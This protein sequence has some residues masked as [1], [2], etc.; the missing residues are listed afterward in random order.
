MA[1]L[2]SSKNINIY[3]TG[4]MGTGKSSVASCLNKDYGMELAEMDE[5]IV[6]QTGH[7]IPQI[8][9]TQGETF[10]RQLETQ[11]LRTLA[12][13]QNLIVSCGGGTVL[14]KE[15]IKLM[16]D[17]GYIILLTASPETLYQR[18]GSDPNRPVLEGHR[19]PEGILQLLN[20]SY[21]DD[22]YGGYYYDYYY[23]DYFYY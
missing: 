9:S 15:N 2:Q 17:S 11:L 1:H 22:D 21:D 3:L 23:D 18:V 10:F 4:F 8:F 19:S 14:K 20:Q 5:L 13:R 6:Q 7:S 16:K 12:S